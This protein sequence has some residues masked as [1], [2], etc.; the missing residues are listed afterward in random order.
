MKNSKQSKQIW[1]KLEDGNSHVCIDRAHISCLLNDS[2]NE[3]TQEKHGWIDV[4]N[5]RGMCLLIRVLKQPI[6]L[7]LEF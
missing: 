4:L 7:C 1:I 3:R 6:D 5:K 2:E